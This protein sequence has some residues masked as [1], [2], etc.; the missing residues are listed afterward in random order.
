MTTIH[1]NGQRRTTP[2]R[3]ITRLTA[4]LAT[5]H[6]EAVEGDGWR[7]PAATSVQ[8]RGQPIYRVT[9]CRVLVYCEDMTTHRN[10]NDRQLWQPVIVPSTLD[11]HQA[12]VAWLVGTLVD[13][14]AVEGL[15]A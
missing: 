10:P 5:V 11:S 12:V 4:D 9:D 1:V 2:R 7:Y 14:A 6:I 13:D 8:H 15:V 3:Q